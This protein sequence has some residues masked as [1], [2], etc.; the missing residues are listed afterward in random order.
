MRILVSNSVVAGEGVGGA[1]VK[2]TD[3]D[4]ERV[5]DVE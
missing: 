3:G 4:D 1:G 2:N 5:E